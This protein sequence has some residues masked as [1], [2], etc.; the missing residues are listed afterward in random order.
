M[1]LLSVVTP[2]SIYQERSHAAVD[3]DNR[4]TERMPPKFFRCGS[5]DH[6]IAKISNQRK[7]NEKPRKKVHFS[8]IGNRALKN[9]TT[10]AKIKMSK[11][12]MHLWHVCLIMTNILVGIFVTVRN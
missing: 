9:N 6:L 2:P 5:E 8:E 12:Y 10:M 11:R 4:R 7:D 1:K 3:S